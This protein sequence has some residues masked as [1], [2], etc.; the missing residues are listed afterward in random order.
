MC[1]I[2][3]LLTADSQALQP[4][5]LPLVGLAMRKPPRMRLSILPPDVTYDYVRVIQ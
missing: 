1:S 2:A 5:D 3:P 4:S